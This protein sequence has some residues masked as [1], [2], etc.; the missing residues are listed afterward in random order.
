[1]ANILE[2]M[3]NGTDSDGQDLIKHIVSLDH[4]RGHNLR[5]VDPL[6]CDIL[7]LP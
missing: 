4:R 6:L 3:N 2:F 5:L 7:E 1:M